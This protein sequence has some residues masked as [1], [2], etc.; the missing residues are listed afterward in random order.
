MWVQIKQ[1]SNETIES[2]SLAAHVA[3][4]KEREATI[5]SRITDLETK[6]EETEQRE[7]ELKNLLLK[8]VSGAFI[9]IISSAFSIGAVVFNYLKG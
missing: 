6:Q 9:A 2:D 3:L 8:T 7:H 5:I 4:S 1:K